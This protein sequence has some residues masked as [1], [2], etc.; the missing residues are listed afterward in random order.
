MASTNKGRFV[1]YE[2]LTRDVPAAIAFYSEVAG[3]KTEPFGPEYQMW[4]GKQGPLGGVMALKPEQ[5]R[6]PPH[7]MAHVQV[8]DVD[9][10]VAQ[11]QKLGAKV[12]HPP[13][14]IP[15]VGRFS[16]LADPQGAVFS[17]FKPGG[18]EMALHDG[19]G[20][21]EFCWNE[22]LAADGAAAFRFYSQ[23]TGWKLL[24]EMDMG[25]MGKYRIFG[26]GDLRLGGMMDLPKGAPT[27]PAWLFYVNTA[28]LDATLGRAKR[29][30]A[31]VINGPMDIPGGGRVVALTD[32]QGA[33]FALHRGPQ[34]G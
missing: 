25:P 21:G 28:D 1:W 22:L 24:D 14:D 12:H 23:L 27:P 33:A 8:D 26:V 30:G 19:A 2:H 29:L 34:G 5:G 9:A 17:V 20:E 7:W 13:T 16:V 10:T 3:W 6:I 15:T 4:V 18:E 31:K 32:P 11:A